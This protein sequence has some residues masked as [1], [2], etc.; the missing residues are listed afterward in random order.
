MLGKAL[1]VV[2]SKAALA[3]LGVL[4]VGGGGTA[5]AVTATGGQVPVL[6]ALVGHAPHA[7][8]HTPEAGTSASSHA[9]TVSLEGVLKGY[10]AGAHTISVLGNGATSA[11][12]IGVNSSTTV[13]GAHAT[14]LGDLSKAIGKKVQVQATKQ[15][16][17]TLLAWKITVEAATP[18]QG[19]GQGTGTGQ[20]QGQQTELQGT[21]SSLG[22]SSFV[23]TLPNG[24]TKTV[25]VSSA[26]LFAGRA[27]KL[28]DLKKG[29]VVS[30]HGTTQS[31]GTVAA[32]SVEDH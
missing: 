8:T 15:G 9:H 1:L 21:V 27:H 6:S 23:L 16:D 3:I 2:K 11:T 30:V 19:T 24:S 28:G 22:T 32:T 7:A 18:T 17:D 26:T 31:D 5:V 20:G 13:N 25:T 12:T 4:V 14:T 29:D 10:D